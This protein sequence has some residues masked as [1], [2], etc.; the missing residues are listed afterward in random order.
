MSKIIDYYWLIMYRL[1]KKRR[2]IPKDI[3]DFEEVYA[4]SETVKKELERK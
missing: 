3:M 2:P 1:F 4:I